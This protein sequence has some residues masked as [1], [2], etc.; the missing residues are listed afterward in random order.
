VYI[1]NEY[2]KQGKRNRLTARSVGKG[3]A[4]KA[5]EV[6]EQKFLDAEAQAMVIT[7]VANVLQAQN[8]QQMK[9]MM[10]MFKK[11]LTSM[12]FIWHASCHCPTRNPHQLPTPHGMSPL[13]QEEL[14]PREV[15]GTQ[16][17]QGF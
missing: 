6:P 4:N 17:Q 10:S 15:L 16:C 13:Q 14:Q 9:N 7:E 3:I 8:E 11:L 5:M 1:Q 12:Q 2:T